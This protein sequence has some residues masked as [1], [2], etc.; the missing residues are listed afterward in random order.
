MSNTREYHYAVNVK[1]LR[2]KS[3]MVNNTTLQTEVHQYLLIM[4]MNAVHS[5]LLMCES[6]RTLEEGWGVKNKLKT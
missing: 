4:V 5:P 6:P 2:R 3:A 1:I